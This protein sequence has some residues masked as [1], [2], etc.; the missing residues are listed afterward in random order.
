MLCHTLFI[1]T[2]GW[3]DAYWTLDSFVKMKRQKGP[4]LCPAHFFWDV[5]SA[6]DVKMTSICHQCYPGLIQ[7]WK[8]SQ[9][10][11]N[12]ET[13]HKIF[14]MVYLNSRSESDLAYILSRDLIVPNP[15]KQR[16]TYHNIYSLVKESYPIKDLRGNP[17]L[18]INYPYSKPDTN[19]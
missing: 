10:F 18:E 14:S 13:Q 4:F 17:S 7:L 16:K 15:G 8:E 5:E 12:F 11:V 9:W 1:F 6:K 2:E 3:E 19:D